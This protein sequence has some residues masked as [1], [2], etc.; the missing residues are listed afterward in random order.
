MA[1][2]DAY[3]EANNPLNPIPDFGA[4]L[5]GREAA[6]TNHNVQGEFLSGVPWN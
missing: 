5:A 4:T 2:L 6:V 1:A 3:I